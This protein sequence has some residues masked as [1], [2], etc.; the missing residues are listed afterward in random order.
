MTKH[1]DKQVTMTFAY[2]KFDHNLH[3]SLKEFP[4]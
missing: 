1:D 2:K 4:I 3:F